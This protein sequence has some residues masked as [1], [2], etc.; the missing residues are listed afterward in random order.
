MVYREHNARK[1]I[2]FESVAITIG[3]KRHVNRNDAQRHM[4]KTTIHN[5]CNIGIWGAIPIINSGV[6]STAK[7]EFYFDIFTVCDYMI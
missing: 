1:C 5:R 2:Y 4:L 3:C 6:V 7:N